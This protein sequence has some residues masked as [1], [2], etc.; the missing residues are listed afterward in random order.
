[1]AFQQPFTEASAE[2]KK[3]PKVLLLIFSNLQGNLAGALYNNSTQFLST[4]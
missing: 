1:M 3:T 4:I 2:W